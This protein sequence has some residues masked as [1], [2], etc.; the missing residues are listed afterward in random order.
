[1]TFVILSLAVA[2]LTRLLTTDSLTEPIRRWFL[3][4]WPNE[5]TKFGD[6]ELAHQERDDP[7]PRHLPTGVEVIN[8]DRAWVALYPKKWSEVLS[9]DWCAAIWIGIAVWI[10]YWFYP[11]TEVILTPLALA[12]V[13]GFLNVRN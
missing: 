2:R 9:C 5:D 3:Y 13:A 8:V 12:Y 11:V 1:M 4:R 10:A 6:S 7:Q